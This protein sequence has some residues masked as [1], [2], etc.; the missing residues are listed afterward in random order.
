MTQKI[1]VIPAPGLLVLDETTGQP[2]PSAEKRPQGTRVVLTSYV[3]KRLACGDLLEAPAAENIE[4]VS[5][6]GQHVD[7]VEVDE[8]TL[9]RLRA[10]EGVVTPLPG[11]APPSD[12]LGTPLED[13][14]SP[15]PEHQPE[16]PEEAPA[17]KPSKKDK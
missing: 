14:P 9:A 6:G 13:A 15:A 10:G 11:T 17:R 2:F 16:Q 8:E 7:H 5:E 3:H 1:N 12:G 4:V